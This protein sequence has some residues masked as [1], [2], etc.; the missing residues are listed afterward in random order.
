NINVNLE[1]QELQ[2]PL[3]NNSVK[4]SISATSIESSTLTNATRYQYK[5]PKDLFFKQSN[6]HSYFPSANNK[7]KSSEDEYLNPVISKEPSYSL[8]NVPNTNYINSHLSSKSKNGIFFQDETQLLQWLETRKDLALQAL[9]LNNNNN[10]LS[11][12]NSLSD[13]D[14]PNL[15]KL[16]AEQSRIL[17]FTYNDEIAKLASQLIRKKVWEK[18]LKRY[19]DILDYNSFQDNQMKERPNYTS[20]VLNRIK[21]LDNITINFTF[22]AASYY[23]YV[24]QLELKEEKENLN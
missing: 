5:A 11:N 8:L 18:P 21:E 13:T 12:K 2:E 14:T 19:I 4:S 6:K 3:Q 9:N 1:A 20:M 23:Q 24:N 15:A 10:I 17:F 22:P 7:D 16:L